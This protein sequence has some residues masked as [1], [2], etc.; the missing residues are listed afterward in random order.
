MIVEHIVE[1]SSWAEQLHQLLAPFD[2]F[3]VGVHAPIEAIEERE[4]ARGNR[5]LGEGKFHVKT[6]DYCK[7][8]IEVDTSHSLDTI[9]S[10]IL[11]AWKRRVL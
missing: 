5:F 8:D 11:S 6:H 7:Y 4:R 3:W 2:T 10:K 9:V 1:E